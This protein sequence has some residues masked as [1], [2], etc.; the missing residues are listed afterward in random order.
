M[1]FKQLPV[2]QVPQNSILDPTSRYKLT[3]GY[4]N[5]FEILQAPLVTFCG[6]AH[7]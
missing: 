5:Q 7:L 6:I 4:I 3:E 2:L 1:L